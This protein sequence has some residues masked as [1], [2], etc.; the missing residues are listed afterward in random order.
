MI[1][2]VRSRAVTSALASSS[3]WKHLTGFLANFSTSSEAAEAPSKKALLDLAEVEKVLSDVKADDVRVIPVRD[4]CD[5]TDYMVVASGRSTWHVRNIA[6]ALI[7]KVKQKQRGSDRL[8]LPSVE[9]S[10]AGKWIV[11]DSGTIIVH[12]LDEKARAYYNLESLWTKE[13]SE[14]VPSPDLEN[15]LVK[16]RRRNNSKKPMKSVLTA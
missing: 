1:S 2:A 8:I 15:A 12:A 11:V 9:G 16:R 3:P 6:Q 10:E 7:H 14:K 13:A 5:C 4:Q